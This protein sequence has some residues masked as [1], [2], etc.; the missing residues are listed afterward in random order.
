MKQK[1][2]NFAEYILFTVDEGYDCCIMDRGV[3]NLSTNIWFSS[4]LFH[5]LVTQ[6]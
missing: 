6:F 5:R 1:K 4:L 3:K 2:V